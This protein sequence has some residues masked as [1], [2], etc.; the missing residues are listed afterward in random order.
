MQSLRPEQTRGLLEPERTKTLLPRESR[1]WEK[2]PH[3]TC[4]K[5]WE[6]VEVG[7]SSHDSDEKGLCGVVKSSTTNNHSLGS[8]R[9]FFVP[10]FNRDAYDVSHLT[11]MVAVV[12]KV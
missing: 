2:P 1:A 11:I 3:P 7:A 12:L 5:D 10:G 4:T 8:V 6:A 9:A